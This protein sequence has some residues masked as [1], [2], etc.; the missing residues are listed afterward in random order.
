MYINLDN[1]CFYSHPPTKGSSRSLP[2]SSWRAY[3]PT[4]DLQTVSHTI[5]PRPPSPHADID[6]LARC[7]AS[8][9]AQTDSCAG[10]EFDI[11]IQRSMT[12]T[13]RI[14]DETDLESDISPGIQGGCPIERSPKNQKSFA[15]GMLAADELRLAGVTNVVYPSYPSDD[16]TLIG[17][18]SDLD[19]PSTNKDSQ[20]C[21]PSRCKWNSCSIYSLI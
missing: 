5:S 3:N 14:T 4:R 8:P 13:D 20:F 9:T 19:M 18:L 10:S 16:F 6:I 7:Q 12:Q 17:T 15:R 2:T 1:I 21:H 11:E